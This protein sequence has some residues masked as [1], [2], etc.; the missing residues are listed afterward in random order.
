MG[1]GS[2][3]RRHLE[4]VR[5]V[6]PNA[7]VSALRSGDI[8]DAKVP[9][10]REFTS[11]DAAINFRPD[12]S[13]VAGP[14]S[15]HLDQAAKLAKAGSHILVEK[16][17]SKDLEGCEELI[18]V[19]DQAGVRSTIGYN[20]RFLECIQKFKSMIEDGYVG[21]VRNVI[22]E[23]G[24]DLRRWRP[25]VDYR[26]SVS[27]SAKLGG[28]VLRELSH[29]LDYLIWIF[30]PPAWVSAHLSAVSD[31]G[32]DVEDNAHLLMGLTPEFQDAVAQCSLL[33]DF[34]RPVPKRS[35][36]AIGT[37]GQLEL[38]LISQSVIYQREGERRVIYD[39]HKSHALAETYRQEVTD[40][41][42]AIE[43]GKAEAIPL[44]AG[45]DV[46]RVIN[47][48]EQSHNGNGQIVKWEWN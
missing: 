26:L 30:G 11:I 7:S 13:I 10:D 27:A 2:A 42:D 25:N 17:L 32:L 36:K 45:L 39:F 28:G 1:L 3:G 33:L 14:A 38:D 48:A 15:L 19:T 47:L 29:E 6:C 35:C 21:S 4:N 9:L 20:L 18:Y 43:T 24:N 31:L 12:L 37:E 23:T 16:P 44:Q 40:F 41:I 34:W 8:G 22:I 46:M 5:I